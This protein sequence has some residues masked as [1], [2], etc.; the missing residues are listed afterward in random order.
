MCLKSCPLKVID[1]FLYR[2][3]SNK[4]RASNQRRPLKS[5]ALL[6]IQI[7]ITACL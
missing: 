7:K 4:R 3:S 6:G 1:T 2:I 5:V